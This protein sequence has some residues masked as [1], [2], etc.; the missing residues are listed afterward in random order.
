MSNGDHDNRYVVVRKTI[1]WDG[2]EAC[3]LLF[4]EQG[5]P[6]VYTDAGHAHMFAVKAGDGATVLTCPV[7]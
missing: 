7:M 2:E 4:T 3:A 6:A 5:S 1:L